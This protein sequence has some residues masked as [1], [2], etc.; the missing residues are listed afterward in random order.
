MNSEQDKTVNKVKIPKNKTNITKGENPEQSSQTNILDRLLSLDTFILLSNDSDVRVEGRYH[1]IDKLNIVSDDKTRDC[2]KL[3]GCIYNRTVDDS[4]YPINVYRSTG[5]LDNNKTLDTEKYIYYMQLGDLPSHT[6]S[7]ISS[8]GDLEMFL[9][10]YT[11][12]ECKIT[13][14]RYV[15]YDLQRNNFDPIMIERFM[16]SNRY[17]S[18]LLWGPTYD[19]TVA[20]DAFNHVDQL[21]FVTKYYN[22]AFQQEEYMFMLSGETVYSGSTVSIVLQSCGTLAVVN[23]VPSSSSEKFIKHVNSVT[24]SDFCKDIPIDV[25]LFLL[26]FTPIGIKKTLS[27]LERTKKIDVDNLE[28][29]R[30]LASGI[31]ESSVLIEIMRKLYTL[32]RGDDSV[33]EESMERIKMIVTQEYL[34][35]VLEKSESNV[36]ETVK[37]EVISL[38]KESGDEHLLHT[39]LLNQEVVKYLNN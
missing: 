26:P 39:C 18:K 19:N 16:L 7:K 36:I 5:I 15:K 32:A 27:I 1:E 4:V 31:I 24:G 28:M 10:T 25:V 8:V 21:E 3:F 37:N 11:M 30:Q 20:I 35:T 14:T 17:M 6:W 33:D 29:I 34:D 12:N 9:K 22:L 23:Y 38:M 13:N 2:A